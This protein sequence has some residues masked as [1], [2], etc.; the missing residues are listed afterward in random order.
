MINSNEIDEETFQE[1]LKTRSVGKLQSVHEEYENDYGVWE[2][3]T[4][5]SVFMNS[6]YQFAARSTCVRLQVGAIFV[7]P[8]Y[9]RILCIGYNGGVSGDKNQCDSLKPGVCGCTHAEMNAIAKTRESLI[10][11]ILF[12]TTSPCKQCA[13]MLVTC[14][15]TKVFY[16]KSYRDDAGATFLRNNNIDVTSWKDY[17]YMKS[18][19]R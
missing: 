18:M 11:S 4:F 3:P 16:G 13:K 17:I 8:K 5:E 9:T 2:R 7:D 6:A 14:G 15:V 1:I 19:Q 12:V 10:G